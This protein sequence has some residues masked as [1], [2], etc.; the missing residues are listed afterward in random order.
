MPFNLGNVLV[1]WVLPLVEKVGKA[2]FIKMLNNWYTTHPLSYTQVL[3][4]GYP[5]IDVQLEDYV[6]TTKTTVD[7]DLVADLKSALES[8]AAT[9]GITLPN[10]DA[11]KPND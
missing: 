4:G 6:K 9:N 5:L 1:D 11:G 7:D 2:G 3:M 10:L 8:S